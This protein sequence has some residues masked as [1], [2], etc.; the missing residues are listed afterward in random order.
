[1]SFKTRRVFFYCLIAVFI[2]LG[3][4]LLT[5]AQ[6]WV[7]DV[8][9]LGIVKTGSVFLKY[10]P[11]DAILEINGKVNESSPG[12]IS[13]G[14]LV[15]RLVPG[16]YRVKISKP[17]LA[18]WEKELTVEESVVTSAT[19]IK[20]WPNA[21]QFEKTSTSSIND[22]WLTGDGPVHE[23]TGGSLRLGDIPIRGESLTLSGPD[24]SLIIT[25]EGGNDLL[26]KLD[27]PKKTTEIADL[28]NFLKQSQL[29]LIGTVRPKEYFLH[30]FN[31]NKV[32]IATA[33]ALY[34]LDIERS[35]L[36]KLADAA[37]MKEARLRGNEI[38]MEDAEGNLGVFNLFLQTARFYASSSPETAEMTEN[39][40]GTLSPEE[41]RLA[42]VSGDA[43]SIR[44]LSDYFVDGRVV[45]KGE[46]WTAFSGK[47]KISDFN[48][49][50]GNSNY[51]L[52][53]ADDG[54]FMTEMDSRTPQNY[55]LI[56]D[57]VKKMAVQGNS[58][59]ILKSDGVLLETG[60]K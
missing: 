10:D 17:D 45:K 28:F 30:P 24:S 15:S 6:G 47:G 33:N 41:K 36:E 2:V 56:T 57:D 9:N 8:K 25:K 50:N 23:T 53:L 26:I 52:V 51:G 11:A 19:Q 42:T 38:F 48:W 27:D 32:L 35:R 18:P 54:L 49:I 40:D 7:L 21:W 37:G 39:L 59:Y 22:F 13:S 20:L 5:L 46:I 16:R 29:S 1:M 34:S 44:A 58:L 55:Y 3:A 60:L 12:L 14:V 43:I 31:G 4:Y